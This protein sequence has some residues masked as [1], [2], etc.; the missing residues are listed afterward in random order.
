MPA[1]PLRPTSI[2]AFDLLTPLLEMVHSKAKGIIDL[3]DSSSD[4]ITESD[5]DSD[6]SE[7]LTETSKEG[8]ASVMHTHSPAASPPAVQDEE[9]AAHPPIRQ[10]IKKNKK[11][12]KAFYSTETNT[13]HESGLTCSFWNR[14]YK[15]CLSLN[16]TNQITTSK[17]S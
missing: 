9:V 7:P 14:V 6:T 13:S 10:R 11:N 17:Q 15:C 12:S 8:L 2:P 3:V 16:V 5:A 1:R 4:A